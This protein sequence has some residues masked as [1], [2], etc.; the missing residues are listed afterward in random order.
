MRRKSEEEGHASSERWL[1]TYSDMITLLLALFIMMYTMSTVD[2][3]KFQSL[4]SQLKAALTGS[5]VQIPP[6]G[7]DQ[8]GVLATITMPPY[9]TDSPAPS[10]TSSADASELKQIEAKLKGLIAD[11]GLNGSVSVRTEE[12]GVV[13][14]LAD[15]LLFD[16]G[17]ADIKKQG[18][19][20]INKFTSVINSI[21]NY[22]RVEGSTDNRP[23]KTFQFPSNWELAYQRAQNVLYALLENG[24]DPKRLSVVDYGEYRPVMPNDTDE[25]KKFNRRVDIVFV[26]KNLNK[27]ELGNK[28]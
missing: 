19:D 3:K 11:A 28:S 7:E 9:S 20:L 6:S 5:E 24:V 2:S 13:V 12:R 21:D 16:S 25:N 22:I 18:R 8:T 26:D 14:S 4:A 27:Y 10:P 1:L 15:A 23:I 17:S